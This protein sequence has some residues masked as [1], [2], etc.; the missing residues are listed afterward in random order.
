MYL[1]VGMGA[2]VDGDGANDTSEGTVEM[3]ETI[4]IALSVW[5]SVCV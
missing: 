5:V 2:E 4:P 1:A 3:K